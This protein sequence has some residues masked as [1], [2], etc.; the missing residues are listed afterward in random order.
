MTKVEQ[1]Q[2]YRYAKGPWTLSPWIP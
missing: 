2:S 1:D